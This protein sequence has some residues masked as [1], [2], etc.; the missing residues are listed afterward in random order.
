MSFVKHIP[1]SIT[2]LNLF[3]GCLGIM[4]VFEKNIELACYCI[5]VAVLF[6]FFDG[7]AARI[8]NVKSEIGKQLDSLADMVSFGVLPG[9]IVYK[10]FGG[11]SGGAEFA[12]FNLT[13]TAFV[14]PVFSAFRLAKFNLDNRQADSFIGLPTPANALFISA[15][16]FITT[17]N[18]SFISVWVINPYFLASI[19]VVL[20]FLLVAELPLLA[21][22]FTNFNWKGNELRFILIAISAVLIIAFKFM[23]LP[24]VITFY[25][26]LSIIQNFLKTT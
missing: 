16:P 24:L 4:L 2:A 19:S 15:L 9:F 14:I 1:N 6:D 5:Y 25:I 20:S 10:L 22:K 23:A 12:G 7:F 17:A 21:L 8:L 11:F 13:L 3:A 26:I 18:I